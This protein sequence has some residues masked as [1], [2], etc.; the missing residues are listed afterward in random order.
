MLD[1]QADEALQV[2]LSSPVIPGLPLLNDS[3]RGEVGAEL[4]AYRTQ[5]R[6]GAGADELNVTWSLIGVSPQAVGV[7]LSIQ[8]SDPD[9][10]SRRV[11]VHWY[12]RIGSRLQ[13]P[14]DLFEGAGWI[15]L[16]ERLV[17][18]LCAGD[19]LASGADEF[20][21]LA[22]TGALGIAF[23]P[24]GGAVVLVGHPGTSREISR[25]VV[26]AQ[27]LSPWLSAEGRNAQSSATDPQP[28]PPPV[29]SIEPS[30]SP[31]PPVPTK[32]PPPKKPSAKKSNT[33]K[34]HAR[35]PPEKRTPRVDCARKRCVA[36]T[37]D[38]GPG[39]YTSALIHT[40]LGAGA[41]ATFFM[42]GE[43][44]D[45]FPGLAHQVGAAGFEI[46]N[47]SYSH[48]D[49]T[50]LSSAEVDA[51][52]ARTNQAI[53][54]A[55]DHRPTLLRPPY[56][57]RDRRVDRIAA[58]S[59]LGEVLWDVDTLDWKHHNAKAVRRAVRRDVRRG[60][61]VLLHDIQP[62]TVQAV[63]KLIAQ[64]RR[65]RYTL[66]TVSELIGKPVPGTLHFRA[67]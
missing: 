1:T 62:T 53:L 3:L 64:L 17:R 60:S 43:H 28:L 45:T 23:A 34:A 49:L 25:A 33:R 20:D 16:R 29:T 63:P 30:E 5:V 15:A 9:R 2:H 31:T 42:I 27:D 65:Q 61:I 51:Q 47:H 11:S 66:V 4:E 39:P 41:P 58:R 21:R 50:R 18:D 7:L 56:G 14:M 35:K 54:R 40:L 44:V 48:P 38:D 6:S 22:A 59:G 19:Q 67:G 13:T 26:S 8:R 12:D 52:L 32:K 10:T 57:A 37:F 55:T 36:L 46:G 24:D